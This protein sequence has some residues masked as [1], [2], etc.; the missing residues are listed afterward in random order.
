MLGIG[1]SGVGTGVKEIVGE[2]LICEGLGASV[3]DWTGVGS[4][5]GDGVRVGVGDGV[6]IS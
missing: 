1:V 3:A 2:G 6:G 5:V 4:G